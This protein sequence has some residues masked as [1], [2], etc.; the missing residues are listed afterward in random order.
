MHRNLPGADQRVEEFP[1]YFLVAEGWQRDYRLPAWPEHAQVLQDD[2][3]LRRKLGN[4]ARDKQERMM[5]VDDVKA[6]VPHG[7]AAPV[8]CDQGRQLPAAPP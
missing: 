4:R 3:F 2:L 6:A 1:E 8:A 7:L 5:V